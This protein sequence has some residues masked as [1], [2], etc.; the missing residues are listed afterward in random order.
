MSAVL[1][2]R[3]LFKSF[4]KLKVLNGVDID[5]EEGKISAIVGQSG[6]GKSVLFKSMIG[7][8]K[9]DAGTVRYRDLELTTMEGEKLFALRKHIGYAFQ[10]AALFDSMSVAENIE[11]PLREVLGIRK[12]PELRRRVAE[13][14][15]WIDLPGIEDMRTDELS[16]GMRK[17]VGVARVLVMKPDVLL[18]DEPTTGLDPVLA[19][20]I[21]NLVIR[22]NRELGLTCLLITHDIPAAFR[23]AD[24]IAFLDQGKIVAEGEPSMVAA[25]E[26][27]LVRN[28]IRTS[29]GELK[30]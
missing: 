21:N 8:M 6:T 11:F 1:Q 29:F 27:E 13:M 22:V 15:D 7:L 17:R 19:E 16:G 30:V 14:L 28:F 2:V 10:N 24:R 20:T 12:K 23:I 5:F 25:S 18:F 9:P 3:G 26:H 4:G